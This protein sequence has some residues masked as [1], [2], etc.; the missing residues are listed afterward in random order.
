MLYVLVVVGTILSLWVILAIERSAQRLTGAPLPRWRRLLIPLPI[1]LFLAANLEGVLSS[2]AYAAS[3]ATT[4]T[5][6][7]QAWATGRYWF[8]LAGLSFLLLPFVLDP[9][10]RRSPLTILRVL[11]LPFVLAPP[12]RQRARLVVVVWGCHVLWLFFVFFPWLM[13]TGVS[14]H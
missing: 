4:F 12:L 3:H 11:L 1:I 7:S 5:R 8:D 9:L 10:L 2:S 13:L 6:D 14:P